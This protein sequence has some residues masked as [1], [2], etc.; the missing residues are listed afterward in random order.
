MT[1]SIAWNPHKGL[2]CL[3]A[4]EGP[5]YLSNY[6]VDY[7]ALTDY[8]SC[9]YHTTF[10]MASNVSSI[11]NTYDTSSTVKFCWCFL[12]PQVMGYTR[13]RVPVLSWSCKLS[14][15]GFMLA[16]APLGEVISLRPV[17]CF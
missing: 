16:Q 8:H 13:S 9:G 2:W 3:L 6:M 11:D 12:H 14:H 4:G 15:R 7:E 10:C 17:S 5:M 1:H